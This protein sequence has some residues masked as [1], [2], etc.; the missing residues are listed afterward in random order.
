[1]NVTDIFI[2]R[3]VLATVISMII[4]LI[5]IVSYFSLPLRQFPELTS[6][7][8]TVAT[9]YSG[10]N[11]KLIE[12]FIT[13]PLETSLSA[14][15]GIDFMSSTSSQDQSQI[16]LQFKLN[17]DINTAIADV[18]SAVA[19]AKWQLPTNVDPVIEKQ[20]P[21]AMPVVWIS[22]TS[23]N[24]NQEGITDYI[25]RVVKPRLQTIDGVSQAQIFGSREY[26]MRVWL[27]PESMAAEGVSASD[28]KNALQA[29][30]LQSATG[31]IKN[32]YSQ[33]AIETNTGLNTA[34]QFNN[35]VVLNQNKDHIIRIKDVGHAELGSES[36]DF[37]AYM[38][39]K[40]TIFVGVI[41]KSTGNPLTVANQVQ[42]MLNQMNP[43]F[44]KGLQA[45]IVWD[46][47]KF[48]AESIYEVKRT[49]IEATVSVI[50]IIFLFLGSLRT[51]TITAV[52]IPLSLIGAFGMM[53]LLGFSI[54]TLTLL[55]LILAI[56]MVVDDAIVVS[57]NI[58]RH[59]EKGRPPI[60]A[61]ILGAREIQFAVIA[62][63]FTLAAVFAPIGFMSGLTG[64]L[65]RE[66]AF[67]LAGT[68]II[69]G[70]IA[71][72][73][74]PMMCSKLLKKSEKE[75]R[76]EQIIIKITHWT[77][78]QYRIALNLVFKIPYLILGVMALVL[79]SIYLLYSHLPKELAPKEDEGAFMIMMN[80]PADANIAY[81]EKYSKQVG[82]IIDK[83]PEKVEYGIVNGFPQGPSS[84]IAF[85][86]LKPWSER[87]RDVDQII[88]SLFPALMQIPGVLAFPFNP[89]SL[90]GATGFMPIEFVL[91]TTAS[92][93]DL[94]KAMG[95][96]LK[97]VA[98]NPSLVNVDTDF[99]LDK[100]QIKLDV[101]RDRAAVLGITMDSI[102]NLLNLA[103]GEP[104]VSQFDFNGRGYDVIPQL[105]SQFRNKPDDIENL[106]L[107]TITG[108]LVPLAN[109]ANVALQTTPR[110]LN[111]FQQL[112]SASLT[113]S[114]APGY[115]MGQALQ[116]L[117]DQAIKVMPDGMK[118][119]FSG[120][121]RQFIQESR[122]ME[123][124]FLFAL[125]FIFLVLSAQFESFRSPLVVMFTVPLATFG[126]LF[127]LKLTGSTINIYTQIGIVTLIGLISKHGI[128][129]TEFANQ[130]QEKGF[131]RTEAIIE[132]AVI[133]LRPILMTTMAM[134]LG[135]IPLTL[136]IGAGA[137]SRKQMGWTIVGGMSIGTIFTLFVIPVMYSWLASRKKVFLTGDLELDKAISYDP[138]TNFQEQ[139]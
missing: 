64:I 18:N 23:K 22:F 57:E 128:L 30:N 72:T 10:A 68:V 94:G 36:Q 16:T 85:A 103:F 39:G 25:E 41:P 56:G 40:Q 79:A 136:A 48:I 37:S 130:L 67:T 119:D 107:R 73:L 24:M 33:Y 78:S 109:I 47:S 133:R 15:N 70:F 86:A 112:R 63:T 52:S 138:R 91:E 129:M 9:H 8:I 84:A 87:K 6:T 14:V 132:A 50:L 17:Y 139:K 59:I 115:T 29:N 5:G 96:L 54:N 113:A 65:F 20:D 106:N 49:I 104:T 118:Y 77:T 55:A 34:K 134:I 43:M 81:T 31:E 105:E 98:S 4:V 2:K 88:A 75:N 7:V 99:K 97:A 26:A 124:T 80:S 100:T 12:G 114:L 93:S 131:S 11:P 27:N 51:L 62:M 3:P 92:Y 90:P 82:D 125:I 45:A 69:S 110:S 120:E 46:N 95:K 121:S 127:L 42:K 101:N 1:M 116:F 19:S 53:S 76:L 83:V 108:E 44:P 60:A 122:S 66:F 13:T 117:K 137:V 35:L 32:N 123:K 126:A 135:A 38:N 102:G 74:S 71:L 58:H 111:H 61:A 89:Y 21:N 28:V